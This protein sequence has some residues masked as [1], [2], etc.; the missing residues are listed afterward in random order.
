MAADYFMNTVLVIKAADS[1]V[2]MKRL[3]S[4]RMINR[5]VEKT[6]A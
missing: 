5:E 2:W 6:D 1:P 3:T 4:H